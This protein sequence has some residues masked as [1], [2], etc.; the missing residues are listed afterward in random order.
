MKARWRYYIKNYFQKI[1]NLECIWL[2]TIRQTTYNECTCFEEDIT[3]K[4]SWIWYLPTLNLHNLDKGI[5]V[6]IYYMATIVRALLL[7]ADR[8]LWK[9]F[10]V[11]WLFWVVSKS[12][13]RVDENNRKDNKLQLYFQ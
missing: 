9:I 2:S 7:A 4:F 1:E 11:R 5:S 13:E 3:F 6:F 10:S 12:Y 8:A